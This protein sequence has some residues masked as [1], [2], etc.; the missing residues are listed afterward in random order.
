MKTW[1]AVIVAAAVVVV[2]AACG[3]TPE[4]PAVVVDEP[5]VDV[6]ERGE[7][8]ARRNVIMEYGLDRSAPEAFA[9]GEELFQEA[10]EKYA[11]R[12]A[13]SRQ[14][15]AQ[16][17]PFYE[18]VI[19]TGFAE[20]IRAEKAEIAEVRARAE[21]ARAPVA[22]KATFDGAVER[23]GVGEAAERDLALERA[24]LAYRESKGLFQSSY[25]QAVERRRRAQEALERADRQL[26]A[27]EEHVRG[28]ERDLAQELEGTE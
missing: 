28:L 25:D 11:V 24:Y 2:M 18:T 10:E 19:A 14:L 1:K 17:I 7:A 26:S 3:T 23:Y 15:Y 27:T 8:V 13:G 9:R 20:R 5:V 22:A 6:P 16:A 21:Q 4:E 12:D